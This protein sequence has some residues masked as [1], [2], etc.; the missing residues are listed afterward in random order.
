M[1]TG[2]QKEGRTEEKR[3]YEGR[4]DERRTEEGRTRRGEINMR[5]EQRLY[6]FKK[7]VICKRI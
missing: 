4:T 6:M 2:E 5:G 3:A 1:R 7:E